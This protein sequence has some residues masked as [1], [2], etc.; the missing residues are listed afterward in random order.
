MQ[1]RSDLKAQKGF[2]ER[3]KDAFIHNSAKLLQIS[4][5]TEYGHLYVEKESKTF[6]IASQTIE[7]DNQKKTVLELTQQTFR[8]AA[9]TCISDSRKLLTGH[10]TNF[11]QLKTNIQKYTALRTHLEHLFGKEESKRFLPEINTEPLLTGYGVEYGHIQKSEEELIELLQNPST[12]LEVQKAYAVAYMLA[13]PSIL[14]E[15]RDST[16]SML[17]QFQQKLRN[18]RD[19]NIDLGFVI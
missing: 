9:G 2:E 17:E 14:A 11:G 8:Q 15:K 13:L 19:Q 10:E 1:Q 6:G 18:I 12:M 7:D 3:Q 5:K 4:S 16:T